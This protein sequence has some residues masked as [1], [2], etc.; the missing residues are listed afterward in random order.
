MLSKF[1]LI[2]YIYIYRL[3]LS[4]SLLHSREWPTS[5]MGVLNIIVNI[6]AK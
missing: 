6:E 4:L 1:A 5:K 3:Y 2:M